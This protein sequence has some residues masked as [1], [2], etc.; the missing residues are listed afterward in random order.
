MTLTGLATA[1][2]AALFGLAAALGVAIGLIR[3]ARQLREWRRARRAARPRITLLSLAAGGGAADRDQL[4]RLP[5]ADWRAV[6]PTALDL[7]TKVR[8]EAHLAL[9]GVFRR[10]GLV[11]QARR[12]LR[13]PGAVRRARAAAVLGSLGDPESVPE[14]CRLLADSH[15]DVRIAAIHALGR[16][17]D[18]AAAGPLLASLTAPSPA[19]AQLVAHALVQLGPAGEPALLAALAHGSP[20]VRMTALDALRLLGVAAA[21]ERTMPVEERVGA[22]LRSDPVLAVRLRAAPALGRIGTR[23]ALPPLLAASQ[24]G[25][26]AQQCAAAAAALGELGAVAAVPALRELLAR[27]EHQVG[28]AAAGALLRLGPAGRTALAEAAAGTGPAAG[29]ARAALAL[30][31]LARAPAEPAPPWPAAAGTGG[32]R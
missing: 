30:A 16:I 15:P 27:P 26:P 32:E 1:V 25:Q 31:A 29:H 8:G 19:P 11:G 7:L 12:D 13:R 5:A 4:V 23:A 10:R 21:G 20:L 9:A 6:Q 28:D 14:L 22:V 2:F 17:G 24:P 3:A 18:P